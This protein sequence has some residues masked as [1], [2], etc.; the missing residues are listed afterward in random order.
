MWTTPLATTARALVAA[1]GVTACLGFV[2]GCG[3]SPVDQ[4]LVSD[5][6]GYLC[7]R[8]KLRFYT[9][10]SVIADVC[11]QCKSSDIREVAAFVCST[12]RHATLAP[13]GRGAVLCEKC[14]K[15]ASSLSLPRET[16]L[17]A[18]NAVRKT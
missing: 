13:R 1:L 4:A 9:D 16:E 2:A 15:P 12:D 11:P 5:A 14:G 6:R 8:C 10:Y 18:W 17:K 7:A 3:K